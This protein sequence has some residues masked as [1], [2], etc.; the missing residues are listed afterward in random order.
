M[1]TPKSSGSTSTPVI[2][3]SESA[4]NAGIILTETNNDIWSQIM[5]MHIVEREKLSY[6]RDKEKE[7]AVQDPDYEKWY[8]ENQKVKR[9][10]LL[11]MSPEI[12]KRYLRLATTREIWKALSNAFYDG[13]DELQVYNLNQKAFTAKQSGRPLSE[14]YGE[15][16]E[17]FQELDHRDKVVM[18]DPEDVT[19]YKKSIGR[20]RVHIF[21]AG[22]DSEFEQIRE[23]I[24]RK[25]PVPELENSYALIR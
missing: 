11:S 21:L 24:L 25:E 7:L 12:M 2:I 1:S 4:F 13:S 3:Q 5:E 23:E 10:L 6:I 8:V 22:L 9:W 15:L 14:Y 19:T 16:V 17:I 18:K 20:L